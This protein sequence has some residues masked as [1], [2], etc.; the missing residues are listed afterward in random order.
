M[1]EFVVVNHKEVHLQTYIW[2]PTYET[3]KAILLV[4]S[5]GDNCYRY[6]WLASELVKQGYVVCAYDMVA[7]GRSG[8]LRAKW[9]SLDDLLADLKL[10]IDWFKSQVNATYWF[11]LGMGFGANL[12]AVNQLETPQIFFSGHCLWAPIVKLSTRFPKVI[13]DSILYVNSFTS[14]LNVL[15]LQANMLAANTEKLYSEIP[16]WDDD[17]GKVSAKTAGIVINSGKT[18]LKNWD[19]LSNPIWVGWGKNDQLVDADWL[20]QSESDSLASTKEFHEFENAYHYLDHCDIGLEVVNSM[21]T[22]LRAKVTSVEVLN[23]SAV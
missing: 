9:I 19:K 1:K 7:H 17:Y 11:G 15:T 23:K 4:H 16:D 13:L 5:Y 2:E 3:N 6:D 10:M 18:I 12:L 22:W 21:K 8:G 20:R 14:H